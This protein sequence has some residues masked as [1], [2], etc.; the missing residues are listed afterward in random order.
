MCVGGRGEAC[1][2][3]ARHVGEEGVKVF[4][5]PFHLLYTVD[6]HSIISQCCSDILISVGKTTVFVEVA[7]NGT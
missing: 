6:L 4:L 3:V 1:V 7:T 5:V 2:C